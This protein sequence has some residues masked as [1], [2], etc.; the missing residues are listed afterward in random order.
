MPASRRHA[1]LVWVHGIA[2]DAVIR[3]TNLVWFDDIG[4][5][6]ARRV[7]NLT[8]IGGIFSGTAQDVKERLRIV[9]CST[10]NADHK[11]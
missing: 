11:R 6:T 5:Y 10:A 8:S 9:Y 2:F 7:A 1:D 3:S 4:L